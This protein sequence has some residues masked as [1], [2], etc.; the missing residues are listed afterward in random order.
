M[1]KLPALAT[2]LKPFKIH[3]WV[4]FKHKDSRS[5]LFININMSVKKCM[6]LQWVLQMTL[7]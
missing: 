7:K 2:E 4:F 5:I 6:L 1:N 3:R